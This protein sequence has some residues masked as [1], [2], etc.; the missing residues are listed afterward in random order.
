V[1]MC[2]MNAYSSV[3]AAVVMLCICVMNAYSSVDAAVVM[4]CICGSNCC[5]SL[6]FNTADLRRGRGKMLL[7]FWKMLELFLT[8]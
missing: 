8:K 1:Y 5:L 2:V 6:Y 7:G 4:L 3:D